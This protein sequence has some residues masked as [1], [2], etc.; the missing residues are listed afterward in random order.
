MSTMRPTRS[1]ALT[2]TAG[3]AMLMISTMVA[4]TPSAAASAG[5]LV[6]SLGTHQ[7]GHLA[8]PQEI[9]ARASANEVGWESPPPGA[10]GVTFGPWSVDVAR[11]G[12]VWLLD[13][14]NERLLV[15]QS[16]RPERPARTV[17]LPFKA[18]GDLA[19]GS[20]GTIYVTSMPAGGSGDYLYALTPTGQVRWKALL[21]EQRTAGSLLMMD[22]VAYY[23]FTRWTP[24]TGSDGQP[25]PA[26]QQRRLAGPHQPL[27]GG[28]RLSE[29]LVSRH[30]LRLSLI[31]KRGHAVRAWR[32]T[33]QAELGGVRAKAAMVHDDLVVVLSVDEQAR[34][35]ALWEYLVLRLPPGGGTTVR[36]TVAP[37]S[38]VMWGSEQVTG[39]RVG[40]DGRLYQL[41][42]DRKTG[43]RIAR[44]SLDPKPAPPTTVTP[45]GG[46]VPPSTVTS[47]P[48]TKVP[49]PTTP[50]LQQPTTPSVQP[51][52]TIPSAPVRSAWRTLAPWLAALVA[53]ALAAAAEVWL[54][55]RRRHRHHPAG[56]ERP[57]PAH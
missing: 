50:R 55:R 23:H 3:L 41:R 35:T 13:E 38:R 9:V 10:D 24:M 7:F 31:D 56:P 26:A 21:P 43:V 47:P 25:L 18:A 2:L 4:P 30:E 5:P 20:D 1:I 15:W 19:L 16:G 37:E 11:D 44:Y 57:R 29:T 36:F 42:S 49:A 54:W 33:S 27:P 8:A 40:P 34:D 14:V 46:P 6:V 52:P 12:S 17:P 45:G 48:S 53:V 28:L 51:Q 22:G 32:I 39:L